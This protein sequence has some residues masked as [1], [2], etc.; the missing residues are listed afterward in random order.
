MYRERGMDRENLPLPA[1]NYLSLF[2]WYFRL[3]DSRTSESAVLAHPKNQLPA[4]RNK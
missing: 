1:S 4:N 3:R 2:F